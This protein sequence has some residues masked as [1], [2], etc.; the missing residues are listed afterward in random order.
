MRMATF[1][2]LGLKSIISEISFTREG[3]VPGGVR[4]KDDSLC[5]GSYDSLID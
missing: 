2:G 1:H 3:L 4:V 5:H